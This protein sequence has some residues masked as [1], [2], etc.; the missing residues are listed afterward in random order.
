MSI[1]QLDASQK[2]VFDEIIQKGCYV[3]INT[4][5][6][7]YLFSYKRKETGFSGTEDPRWIMDNV[8]EILDIK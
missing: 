4:D 1:K 5:L 2:K 3:T 6:N 7:E 8:I